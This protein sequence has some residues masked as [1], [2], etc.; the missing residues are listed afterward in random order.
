MSDQQSVSVRKSA[1]L[2]N[3]CNSPNKSFLPSFAVSCSKQGGG[4]VSFFDAVVDLET[5]RYGHYYRQQQN[6]QT[7]EQPA[8][9]TDGG[10]LD[11]LRHPL[12]AFA[13]A[14]LPNNTAHEN[15]NWPHICFA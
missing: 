11:V 13:V 6:R 15:F 10:L 1:E 4:W 9:A 5:Q 3:D 14:H 2:F 7:G 8:A 12:N